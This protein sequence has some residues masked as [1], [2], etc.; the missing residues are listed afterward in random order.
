MAQE[1]GKYTYSKGALTVHFGEVTDLKIGRFCSIGSDV[2]IYLRPDHQT[3][4]C[5]TYPLQ[6]LDPK[7]DGFDHMTGKGEVVIGNDVWIG[8]GASIMS[9]VH[10]EDGAVIGAHSMVT[11]D[12]GAY[13]IF[14]GNPAVFKRLR[15]DLHF[16]LELL[17]IKW[18]DWPEEW[19]LKARPLLL[20]DNLNGLINF[21]ND[22][23]DKWEK[24][25]G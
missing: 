20:S 9:G 4:W 6:M 17:K 22:N 1:V 2:Q 12:V 10:I 14:A 19:I 13:N 21:Y 25:A 24:H 5:T 8:M 3:G 16:V 11:K 7:I 18:W 23:K 15:F